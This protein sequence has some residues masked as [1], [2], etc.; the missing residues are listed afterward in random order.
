MTG[1]ESLSVKVA[2]TIQKVPLSWLR[3]IEKPFISR[4]K[5][6][7]I[8]MLCI[9]ALPRSG[10]TLTYQSI[11]HRFDTAYLSNLGNLLY[12]LPLV[13]FRL[14]KW[15]CRNHVSDFT[16][17]HGFVSGLC[18][19]AEGL[20]F[21]SYWM[22]CSLDERKSQEPKNFTKRKEYLRKCFACIGTAE[23]PV[24]SG[25]LGHSLIPRVI[26]NELPGTVFI[27]LRRDPLSNAVSILKAKRKA[28]QKWFSIFPK[29]CLSVISNSEHERVA[30]QVYWLN[31]RL[32]EQCSN[33]ETYYLNYEDL[34]KNPTF[35]LGKL[36]E[37]CIKQGVRLTFNNEMPSH[38]KYQVIHPEKC[39]DAELIQ[40][41]LDVLESE[42]GKIAQ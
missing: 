9:L 29:E 41:H 10:S 35:E 33:M 2:R 27:R 26:D 16:S 11:I 32:D 5:N 38:F 40:K 6:S 24:L 42:H 25:F 36:Q 13:G 39:R 18:G 14:S 8:K 17:N 15:W 3:V 1:R 7:E 22:G 23:R 34:C 21:W 28:G 4:V 19:P 31:K 37:Y 20:K 30:S 12:Q